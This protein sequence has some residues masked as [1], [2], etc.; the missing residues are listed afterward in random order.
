MTE[1][2]YYSYSGKSTK[3]E[4]FVPARTLIGVKLL[5]SYSKALRVDKSSFLFIA[6][7]DGHKADAEHQ[8]RQLRHIYVVYG[9]PH[10]RYAWYAMPAM[11]GASAAE[12]RSLP[13]SSHD[14][15]GPGDGTLPHL[16]LPGFL[17]LT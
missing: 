4:F 3:R 7:H 2:P 17:H 16:F 8:Q 14:S 10:D 12:V 11:F 5:I 6:G 15:G 9:P 1:F 13:I